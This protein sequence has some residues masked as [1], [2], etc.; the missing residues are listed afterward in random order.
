[1]MNIEKHIT[2]DGARYHVISYSLET[3]GNSEWTKRTCSESKCE[4]NFEPV[5]KR[6][7]ARQVVQWH[8]TRGWA[9]GLNGSRHT[10]HTRHTG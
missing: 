5:Y 3:D 6:E 7:K 10:T 8:E 4:I 9:R 2:E 1:M